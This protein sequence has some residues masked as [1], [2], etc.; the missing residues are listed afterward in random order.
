VYFGWRDEAKSLAG[1]AAYGGSTAI[2]RG[3][4]DPEL[5]RGLQVSRAYFQV[6]GGTPLMGRT[7]TESEDVPGAARVIV[8]SEALWKRMYGGDPKILDRTILVDDEPVPVVG[9]MPSAFGE[10]ARAQYWV[11]YRIRPATATVVNYYSLLGRLARGATVESTRAEL[12]AIQARVNQPRGADAQKASPVVMTWHERRYGNTRPALLMLFGAVGVLLL[13]ACVNVANLVLARAA[14]RQ[15]E[16]ALRVALGASRWR[17]ARYLLTESLIVATAGGALALLVAFLSVD[18]FVQI[19]P[20]AIANTTGIAVNWTVIGFTTA[21]AMI[22]GVMFGLVP[23]FTSRR[24]NLQQVFAEGGTRAVGGRRHH[25]LRRALVVIELA[26]SLVLLVGAGLLARSFA[27]VTSIDS[28]FDLERI[29]TGEIQLSTRRYRGEAAAPFFDRLLTNVRAIPGV[30]SAAIADARPLRRPS[31][32]QT[33]ASRPDVTYDVSVVSDDYFTAVGIPVRRGRAFQAGDLANGEPVAVV[34]ETLARVMF[35][36]RDPLTE[37]I[38]YANKLPIRIVGVVRDVRQRGIEASAAP[39]MYRPIRQDGASS[40]MNLVVRAEGD[41]TRLY[42]PVREAMRAI[43]PTQP[44]PALR[45]M[46]DA[47]A[48]SVTPRRFSFLVLGIFAALAALLAAVGLGGVM[49]YLVAERTPEFGVRVALGA[50]RA[51]V[52]RSVLRDVGVMVSIAALLGLAGSLLAVRALRTMV[53][54]V[55]I[56]DPS[57]FAAGAL[58]LVAV[59]GVACVLPAWRATRVDPVTALRA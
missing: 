11:P 28:G 25:R 43:D 58:L 19:S 45:T 40:Y 47:L 26:T 5:V 35:P 36:D 53:Y 31:Y 13:I 7:F 55:S 22:T 41:L 48:E 15:R 42:T 56:Y 2:L 54:E 59:A 32:S 16:F 14:H 1:L 8:L 9:V 3:Q 27:T 37:T 49:S 46:E 39:M 10:A 51:D 6:L 38:G 18:Y 30:Q 57:M 44:P 34:N 29:L 20:A 50:R 52:L 23:V 17:L 21:V 12:A 4:G 33:L 24:A